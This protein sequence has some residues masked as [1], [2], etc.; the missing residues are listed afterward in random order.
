VDA[1]A[2]IA[3]ATSNRLLRFDGIPGC[4]PKSSFSRPAS[5]AQTM[6]QAGVPEAIEP[7]TEANPDGYP[8]G[9]SWQTNARTRRRR[10]TVAR[11]NGF[12]AQLR[13]VRLN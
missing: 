3:S 10:C 9:K 8:Y 13:F 1:E 12:C 6:R 7:S 11:G 4:V 5:S 2:L